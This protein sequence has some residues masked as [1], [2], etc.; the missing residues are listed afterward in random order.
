VTLVS[1]VITSSAPW[2]AA[3]ARA[4]RINATL[5]SMSPTVGLICAMAMARDSGMGI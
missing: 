1:P 5:P 3:S 4:L 2:A